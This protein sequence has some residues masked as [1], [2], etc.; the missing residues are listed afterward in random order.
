MTRTQ[1]VEELYQRHGGLSRREAQ[2]RANDET[3]HL[4]DAR[5]LAAMKPGAV[6]VNTSRG[7]VVEGTDP[8]GHPYF[9]FGLHPFEHTLDH[10]TDLEA[11]EDGFV[12]VTPLQLDLTHY[13]S[14]DALAGRFEGL[15]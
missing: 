8:R 1:L 9:W 6:L 13:S 10:G 7:S 14:I 2:E 4:I 5:A 11:I 12:A 15:T 3:R